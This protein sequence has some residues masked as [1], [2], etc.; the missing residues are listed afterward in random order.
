MMRITHDFAST[1][2][3]AGTPIHWLESAPERP[4]IEALGGD[5]SADV[6]IVGGGYTGLWTAIHLKEA[7]PDLDVVVLE[8]ASVGHGASGRNGGF[9][10]CLLDFSLAHL[11]RRFGTDAAR[12]SHLAVERTID[13]M[14]EQI[15]RLEVD[16]DWR[17]G[18]LL[19]V[20]TNDGQRDRLQADLEAATAMGLTETIRPVDRAELRARVDSPTYLEGVWERQCAV[21]HPAKLV[22]GMALAALRLGVR[23]Y[24]RTPV[25][26]IGPEGSVRTPDGHVRADQVVLATNAWGHEVKPVGRKVRALYTYVILTEP[27]SAEQWSRIGWDGFEGIEDKRNYVHYYRRTADGRILWGGTDALDHGGRIRPRLDQ[28]RPVRSELGQTF[29]RT[30]PALGPVRFTHHWGGPIGISATFVPMFGTLPGGRV[31]YGLAYNGHGV[32][33]SHLGGKIL[34]DRVL[35]RDSDLLALPFVDGR[36]IPFPPEPLMTLGSGL[37]R[38]SL[39]RQDRRLDA[40]RREGLTEPP[41]L[42]ALDRL[43]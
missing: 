24:Q 36:E 3:G 41:L 17:K 29:A 13:E 25:L 4:A 23:L 16:C 37:T 12:A 34:R 19:M 32:A 43:N 35:G 7:D 6:A 33:P 42:R 20:A 22:R 40:G 39:R 28:A 5:T 31:H 26:E 27:L 8:A 30:F 18:G 11:H 9:A 21:L 14:E 2:G 15:A 38:W 1:A 10:M